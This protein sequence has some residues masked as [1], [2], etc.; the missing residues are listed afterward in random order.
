MKTLVLVTQKGGSGKSSLAASLAVA[1]EESGERVFMLDID[2][3]GTLAK[4]IDRRKAETPGFDRVNTEAELNAALA[5]LASQKF[6][7]AIIDTPGVD[8]PLVTAAIRAADLC[9]IP[10]RP[11]PADLEATQPTLEAIQSTRRQ[12]AFVLNQTPVRSNRLTEAAAG[13]KMLGV[14]AEPAI[15]QR[16]DHQDALGAGQGVTEFN[17]TGKAADEIRALWKWLKVKLKG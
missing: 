12:F 14:L 15:P 1:A 9:L 13:L 4:W 5:T 7:L 10:T 2:R 16:N 8:S 3:Q 17:P 6:T 11:T